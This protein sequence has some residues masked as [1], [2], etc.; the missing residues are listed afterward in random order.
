MK[1]GKRPLGYTIVEVMIVLAISGVMFAIAASF[2]SGKQAKT[3]F[4]E[5][6][7]DFTSQVQ[8]VISQVIDGQFSDVALTCTAG[9]ALSFN[10]GAAQG[11]QAAPCVFVGKFL[12]F[13]ESNNPSNY[14]IFSLAGSRNVTSLTGPP[15]ITPVALPY[16]Q[17]ADADLT[18]Q[19]VIPQGLSINNNEANPIQVV[20]SNGVTR[21][22][23]GFGFVQSLGSSNGNG[24]FNN[25]G[26][27]VGL[28]YSSGLGS[29]NLN[30]TGAAGAITGTLLPATSASI[31]LTDGTRYA[32][33]LVGTNGNQL[34]AT[35][36]VVATC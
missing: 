35:L 29:N 23:F 16:A 30:E 22:T 20:D 21:N 19:E 26:Q 17:T 2:I 34:S 18:S 4:T 15:P 36:K 11:G 27:T 24:G 28:V 12:H 32:Q 31:C 8:G 3:E 33:V 14:E 7:N 10:T 1:G 5:G 25:G 9:A 13:S 6:T